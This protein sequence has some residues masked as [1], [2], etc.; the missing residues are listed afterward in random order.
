MKFDVVIVGG[1]PAGSSL[2]FMLVRAGLSVCII[3]KAKFPRFKLCGGLLTEKS[4][5]LWEQIYAEK[6]T[7]YVAQ[8]STVNIYTSEKKVCRVDTGSMFHLIDREQFDFFLISKYKEIGGV[9]FEACTIQTVDIQKRS[10]TTTLAEPI[11]YQILVGADGANS[12]IRKLIDS[13]Y[14]P[15]GFCLEST[16]VNDAQKTDIDLY[17]NVIKHGYGWIFP[18]NNLCTIGIGCQQVNGHKLSVAWDEYISAVAKDKQ[19]NPVKGAFLPFGHYVA[20][21]G[22]ENIL[23]IGDA[24][25]LVDPTT[26][27]GLYFAFRSAEI[28]KNAI[29]STRENDFAGTDSLYLKNISEIQR[30]IDDANHINI[31]FNNSLFRPFL[32][33]AFVSRPDAVKYICRNLIAHYRM[34]YMELPLRYFLEMVY[35]FI[36]GG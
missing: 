35:R 9:L 2:G 5:E 11:E 22:R 13:Q 31:I 21:P 28:A 34:G 4:I 16:M 8:T 20:H 15:N 23:L 36:T 14:R 1:G 18:K 17:F 24:A 10:L 27:E 25:G 19:L 6:F 12:M 33:W 30:I 29:T 3:E 32:V 7:Q 26:G